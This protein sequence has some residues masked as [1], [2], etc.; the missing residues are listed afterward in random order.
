MNTI[1]QT[2]LKRGLGECMARVTSGGET[3]QVTFH[4]RMQA[5][6][7]PVARPISGRELAR[8]LS[9]HAGDPEAAEAVGKV[10]ADY[11]REERDAYDH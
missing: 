9:A 7:A 2:E 4:G 11:E 8:R 10:L 1:S 5:R 6:I 3:I